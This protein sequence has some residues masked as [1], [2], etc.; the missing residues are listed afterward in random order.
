[1]EN[2]GVKKV[3]K[4]KFFRKTA[5]ILSSVMMLT[6]CAK[7]EPAE[8]TEIAN[9]IDENQSEQAPHSEEAETI[10]PTESTET[11][12]EVETPESTEP[13]NSDENGTAI[14]VISRKVSCKIDGKEKATGSF[15]E[16]ILSDECKEKYPKLQGRIEEINRSWSDSIQQN[17]AEYATMAADCD[18]IEDP[19]FCSEIEA[20]INRFD[21]RIF[22]MMLGSYDDMGGAHPSH[23]SSSIVIDP[24]TGEDLKLSSILKD[25]TIL[26]TAIRDELDKNYPGVLEEVDNYYFPSE[27][28]DPD[29]FKQKLADNNYT[30]YVDEKGLNIIFSPYEIASYATGYLEILLSTEDY[31]GLLLEQYKMDPATDLSKSVL[32]QEGDIVEVEAAAPEGYAD[33]G[34]DAEEYISSIKVENPT[35][36]KYV[37]DSAKAPSESHVSLTKTV[38]DKTDWL[39]TEVWCDKNGF[40]RKYFPYNDGNY[41]YEGTNTVDYFYDYSGLDI[42][43]ADQS[44]RLYEF[45]FEPFCYGPDQEENRYASAGEYVNWAVIEDNVLYISIKYPGY[46]S[47]NPW[48]GYIAAISL[49]TNELLWKSEP[50]VANADNFVIVDD[51]LICGYGFT[52]EPDYIYL[53]DKYTGDKVDQIKVN[54]APAQFE[55]VGD[56][57][58]VATY[59]TAYQFTITK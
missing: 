19:V 37:S 39:D 48:S 46:A 28:D 17:V 43:D 42:Y 59:N 33:Y 13:N 3:M 34:Y 14:T 26:T 4:K 21:D 20:N 51:T 9:T 44:T 1:M 22:S 16:I 25:D 49:E 30:W 29:Q 45:D 54:S 35:W 32:T 40:T 27:G 41:Y 10:E 57:L 36:K 47:E 53:L 55:V 8:E 11:P 52:A 23:Y 18:Y 31:P 56:T 12:E 2:I 50:L 5:I 58:Y 7:T 15:P 38:E 24:V 6:A